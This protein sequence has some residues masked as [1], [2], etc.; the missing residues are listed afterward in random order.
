MNYENLFFNTLVDRIGMGLVHF[1]WQGA[2]IAVTL[3]VALRI[4]RH[5][6]PQARYLAAWT[7]LAAMTLC[8]PITAYYFPAAPRAEIAGHGALPG[9]EIA[10]NTPADR[11]VNTE[12]AE[13]TG[14]GWEA[15][16][17][18][19]S[20]A[21]PAKFSDRAVGASP[22][23]V[24]MDSSRVPPQQNRLA[25]A[26]WSVAF[27]VRL[28]QPV[29]PWIVG[30]WL[31]G[32]MTL[33][34]WH[35]GGFRHLVRLKRRGI[36]PAPA[37]IEQIVSRLSSRLSIRCSISV[38]VSQLARVPTVFGWLRPMVL[39]PVSILGEM[40]PA[41]LE[42]ILAHELA[43]V[44][45]LDFLWNLLQIAIETVLFYHPAV[46]WVSRRI[47]EERENCCDQQAIAAMGNPI[48]YAGALVRL[49]E[50]R[51]Q[52]DQTPAPAVSMA[53]DGGSLESRIR[54]VLGLPVG[55]ACNSNAWLG[56]ILA[57]LILAVVFFVNITW[58]AGQASSDSSPS[59]SGQNTPAAPLSMT[60]AAFGRLSD[61]GQRDLLAK[62][63][64]QHL[65][66]G[67]NL[68]YE[69]EQIYRAF[70]SDNREPGKPA[71]K[72]DPYHRYLYRCWQLGNSHKTEVLQYDDPKQT[73]FASYSAD[74]ENAQEGLGRYAMIYRRGEETH[75]QG[76]VVYPYRRNNDERFH[77]FPSPD[78]L[79]SC[80][81]SQQYFFEYL[82]SNR[83]KFEIK[84]PVSEDKVQLIVPWH[85]S[86]QV[87]LL[88]P[89]KGFLPIRFEAR[90]D[91]PATKDGE[92]FWFEVKLEVQES[93]LV[94]N[95]WMPVKMETLSPS[96]QGI[97]VIRQTRV[98]RTACGS[99]T[100]AD[101]LL[102]FTKG[103]QVA[104]VIEG[105][106]YTADA[107]GVATSPVNDDP[108]W[109]HD[110]PPGWHKGRVDEAYSLASKIPAAQWRQLVEQREAKSKP[111][112][113]GLRVL[114]ADPP[115]SQEQR[116]EAA[117]SILRVCPTGER[118]R[119]WATAIRELITIGKPAVP[120]LI[121]ELDRA[122]KE[123]GLRAMGFVLRGI[124]D[125]RAVPALIRAI[126]RLIQP[127]SSDCGLTIKNDPE[128]LKFMWMNDLDHIG[129]NK[130]AVEMNGLILFSYDRSIREIMS[131]LEK[132]TRQSHGWRQLDSAAA[133]ADGI[134]QLRRQR[135]LFLD[136]AKQWADWWSHNWKDF[137]PE[138]ADAQLQQ[139]Q[140]SLD[141]FAETIA[142][143]PQ[144][145]L[146][147][148]IPCGPQV[149]IGG[150]VSWH[151]FE[152][153]LNLG[154][155][156]QPSNPGDLLKNSP[157]DHPSPDLLAW[158]QREGIDLLRIEIKRPGDSKTYY[159]YQPV[160]IRVWKIDNKRLKNLEKE[161]QESKKLDVPPPWEGPI[162]SVD[163]QA[164]E[165]DEE[166]PATFLFIT[167]DGTC[168]TLQIR[169]ALVHEFV[170]GSPVMG[171][172]L[173]EYKYIFQSEPAKAALKEDKPASGVT[174]R[175]VKPTGR[176][177]SPLP[178]VTTKKAEPVPVSGRVLYHDGTPAAKASVFLVGD[179]STTIGDG[180][181]W[182]GIRSDM[183]EDKTITK[184]ITDAAG[185]FTLPSGD[186]K[187]IVVSAPRLDF[188]VVPPPKNAAA[189]D[190]EFTIKL[191]APG[192]L[193]VKYDIPGGDAKA[194]LF[195]QVN[196]WDSPLS[197]GIGCTPGPLVANKGQVVLDNLPPGQC[198]LD[199]EKNVAWGTYFCDRRLLTIESGGTVES[200]FI[201]DRGTAVV[202][203]VVGLTK[204]MRA[205]VSGAA[206]SA[207]VL[208]SVR[209]A[210]AKEG[211]LGDLEL[212][213]FDVLKCGLDG[214][215]RTEQLLP[216]KY[217]ILVEAWLP[218]K[219]EEMS[220]SGIRRS[221]FIGRAVAT[222]PQSGPLLQVKVE[223][224][225]RGNTPP[226][227]SGKDGK[228]S[229][230]G[231]AKRS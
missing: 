10:Q 159:G 151:Q 113:E 160:G 88:D 153:Y 221:S 150:A 57:V 69:T 165:I 2:V 227:E 61:A 155:R 161:L 92:G 136:H 90:F 118:E 164:G 16:G 98:L 41:Q 82:A 36:R 28:F 25:K 120:R 107:Q 202:G 97:M 217:A 23:N 228:G 96:S 138:E 197:R 230:G 171:S 182:H 101:L 147:T 117:L 70:E 148:E 35:L 89:Q 189:K 103:M 52:L 195:L 126:P 15:S 139:T 48:V 200:N 204:E 149:R 156:R 29:L 58:V 19:K 26:G 67:R 87:F 223:L 93:R 170:P 128:L 76:Q 109:K 173:L 30:V 119:D 157:K 21:E 215:F 205:S 213:L 53:A 86:K 121:E 7:A 22:K 219:P 105:I 66:Q 59:T 3:S 39:L 124:G 133:K 14:S 192:R 37:E 1:L 38:H 179:D 116:I 125:P 5:R 108:N 226:V 129:N 122:D 32:V 63:F 174:L 172:S 187:R 49:A 132:L 183:T 180:K 146:P 60:A 68:F 199:R 198:Y 196:T 181:A 95:V 169:S 185:R 140:K 176:G 166:E 11:P 216:G 218:E 72:F 34:V 211:V 110:P 18:E 141:Q 40:P 106:T 114:R 137:V 194:K 210:E 167:R 212:P 51:C 154:V 33:A 6:S 100:P 42:M 62:A 177:N 44:R 47:R 208:V 91:I 85:G 123:R 127:S 43:H 111:I 27:Y 186:A 74:A 222:V 9:N 112:D 162:S 142:R 229:P 184:T 214:R 102:P 73:D 207:G 190:S 65:E 134:I 220:S 193:V 131:T 145:A 75:L 94:D 17:R 78:D 203:Q 77:T 188:W 135:T 46:W 158:A 20:D 130:G 71:K 115:A 209:P 178:A 50:I 191:P 13:S 144:R 143:M 12:G 168:G 175:Q 163:R 24:A 54:R 224:K 206:D 152:P 81:G 31:F 83:D 56:G 45:R 99:V 84:S 104:D 79:M 225:P 231:P 4:L 64:R 201:R 55:S 80:S 8:L